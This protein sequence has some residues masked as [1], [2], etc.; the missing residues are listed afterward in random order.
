VPNLLV[1]DQPSQT[2]FPD[3][4][5]EESE[6]EELLAV[7]KVFQAL[8]SGIKR[9]NGHLQVI[10]SEHAGQSVVEGL[11]NVHLVERW[12]KGLKLIPWHWNNEIPEDYIGKDAEY[13]I[14]D[15]LETHIKPAF[16]GHK[17]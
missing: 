3:N 6:H 11:D 8:S 17:Y 10:V 15:I 5:D 14:E 4:T 7:N 12:R 13:A 9:T 1:I 2:H 16:A